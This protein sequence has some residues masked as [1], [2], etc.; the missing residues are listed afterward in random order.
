VETAE[1]QMRRVIDRLNAA[2]DRF[3]RERDARKAALRKVTTKA[4]EMQD[5][6]FKMRSD[7]V[8]YENSQWKLV[9]DGNEWVFVEKCDKT[10]QAYWC[11]IFEVMAHDYSFQHVAEKMWCDVE[12]WSDVCRKACELSPHKLGYDLDEETKLAK[13]IKERN[14]RA[15]K[16]NLNTARAKGT[17]LLKP[18]EISE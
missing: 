12:M 15:Q 18:S 17:R 4:R 2:F 10:H 5:G 7:K 11:Y 8:I 9:N 1:Q 16:I 3:E 14:K 6:A 13:K